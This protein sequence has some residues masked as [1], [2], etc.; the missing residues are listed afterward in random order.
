M[1]ALEILCLGEKGNK[2]T[3]DADANR[4]FLLPP[5]NFWEPLHLAAGLEEHNHKHCRLLKALDL[6]WASKQEPPL[7]LGKTQAKKIIRSPSCHLLKQNKDTAPFSFCIYVA[8]WNAFLH[9]HLRALRRPQLESSFYRTDLRARST[10]A[11]V[12]SVNPTLLQSHHTPRSRPHS[13]PL[14][15]SS[16]QKLLTQPLRGDRNPEDGLV[17]LE[18]PVCPGPSCSDTSPSSALPPPLCRMPCCFL[19]HCGENNF[20]LR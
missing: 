19:H 4:Y 14:C 13:A 2:K 7:E 10:F 12:T 6:C 17:R 11:G 16:T 18:M 9:F 1:V 3:E 5:F 8:F 15:R 20:L